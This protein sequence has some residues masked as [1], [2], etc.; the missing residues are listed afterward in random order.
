[1]T[2]LVIRVERDGAPGSG[3]TRHPHAA[4]R[5]SARAAKCRLADSPEIAT[6]LR[7][8][9]EP[10]HANYLDDDLA[11]IFDQTGFGV[12]SAEPHLV[13]KVLVAKRS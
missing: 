1:M 3:A 7:E 4:H 10:F 2:A 8:F 12:E 5:G 6:A 13:T 11:V 9:H